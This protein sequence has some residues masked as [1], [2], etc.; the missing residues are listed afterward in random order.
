[1]QQTQCA[2]CHDQRQTI[3]IE[4][5]RPEKIEAG[6]VHRGD[7]VTRH[8]I[9]ARSQPATCL[10]CH[11]TSSCD[12]CHVRRGV[13]ANAVGSANPHP[14]G[15]VGPDTDSKNHH[16]ARKRNI[17]SA[18]GRDAGPAI[19]CIRRVGISG[20]PPSDGRVR[21]KKRRCRWCQEP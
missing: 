14:I 21:L 1:V 16:G 8:P 11:S 20:N 13:S 3:P 19:N 5:R 4:V 2:D 18:R 7:F 12:S 10:K 17:L 9:E 6:F 15:W